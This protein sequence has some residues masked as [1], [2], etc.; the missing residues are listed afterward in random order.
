MPK[1]NIVQ[2]RFKPKIKNEV[3]AIQKFGGF[4]SLSDTV[5]QLIETGLSYWKTREKKIAEIKSE[6]K[7]LTIKAKEIYPNIREKREYRGRA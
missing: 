6:V 5:R 7:E 3:L 2:I 1:T 4:S